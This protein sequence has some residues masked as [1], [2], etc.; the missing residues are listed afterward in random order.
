MLKNCIKLHPG[1]AFGM[2]PCSSEEYADTCAD[3]YNATGNICD[4]EMS[5]SGDVCHYVMDNT[6]ITVW[7]NVADGESNRHLTRYT[8]L[9]TEITP[10][11]DYFNID[12]W[13]LDRVRAQR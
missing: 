10:A 4:R 7:V 3:I 6:D 1:N 5:E 2:L 12:C 11:N 9:K 13:T 8:L